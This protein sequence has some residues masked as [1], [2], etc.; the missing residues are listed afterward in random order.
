MKLEQRLRR[1]DRLGRI[2]IID[3]LRDALRADDRVVFAYIHGSILSEEA[4]RDIDL[5][6]WLQPGVDPLGYILAEG[7]KL[8]EM[9]GVPVDI[10]VL[11]EAPIPFR[12]TVYTRGTPIL[13]RDE[14]LHEVEVVKT[15]L[16]YSVLQLLRRKAE[17]MRDC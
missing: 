7:L 3:S 10:H 11:N 15:I 9:V 12:Y 4:V 6:V 8:E 2:R 17:G 1:L 16:A 14:Y 5:A 13:V